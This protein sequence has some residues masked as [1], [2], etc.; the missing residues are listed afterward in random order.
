MKLGIA[1]LAA[2]ATLTILDALWLGIVSRSFVQSEIGHLF[3]DR[4]IWWAAALF[5]ILYAGAIVY[6]AVSTSSTLGGALARGA[7]LG[8]VAYMTYDL[9]NLA[10]LRDWPVLF[11]CVDVAWGTFAT[12][13]A[14]LVAF[15]LL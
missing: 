1:Y 14:A 15:A 8:F 5:Y 2:F 6:F 11:V 4:I 9:T 3:G 12:A 10:T 7:A 13:I